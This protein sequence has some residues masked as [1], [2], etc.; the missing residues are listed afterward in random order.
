[1]CVE[2]TPY[3]HNNSANWALNMVLFLMLWCWCCLFNLSQI[4]PSEGA[5]P[6]SILFYHDAN[7]V[8]NIM[9]YATT[10]KNW[11]NLGARKVLALK[12]TNV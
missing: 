12:Y 2:S 11:I 5:V 8:Q 10:T 6:A 1:M 9:Q 4:P 3:L 7:F